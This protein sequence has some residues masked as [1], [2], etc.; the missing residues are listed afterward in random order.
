MLALLVAMNNKD[1]YKIIGLCKFSHSLKQP[2]S[3][4]L[5]NILKQCS[6]LDKQSGKLNIS[7]YLRPGIINAT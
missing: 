4:S 1:R 2:F 6:T 5:R 3:V 7:I